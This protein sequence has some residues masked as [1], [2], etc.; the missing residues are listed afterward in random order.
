MYPKLSLVLA[1]GLLFSAD[2]FSQSRNR[3]IVLEVIASHRTIAS[4]DSYVCLRVFSDSTAEWQPSKHDDAETSERAT[5]KETLTP[6]QFKQIKSVVDAP[7]LAKVGPE[8]GNWYARVDTWTEWTI[9]IQ[10]P[11][12]AQIIQ[13]IEFSPAWREG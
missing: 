11:K 3:A 2:N 6:E 9:K 13:V 8:F 12:Q 4:D 7:N 10:R 5:V 1:L